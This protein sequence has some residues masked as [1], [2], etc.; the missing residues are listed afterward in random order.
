MRYITARRACVHTGAGAGTQVGMSGHD[1]VR[2]AHPSQVGA[3]R[4]AVQRGHQEVIIGRSDVRR[5][6]H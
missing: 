5:V 6:G 3:V 4:A 2:L 1:L